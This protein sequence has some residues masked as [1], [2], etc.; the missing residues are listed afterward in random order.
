M[1]VFAAAVRTGQLAGAAAILLGGCV[2]ALLLRRAS[3]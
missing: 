1:G 3:R 2:R